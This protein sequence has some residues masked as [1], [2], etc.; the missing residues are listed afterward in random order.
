MQEDH[1]AHLGDRGTFH[2]SKLRHVPSATAAELRCRSNERRDDR[3]SNSVFQALVTTEL[4]GGDRQ[5]AMK[6][7]RVPP[8]GAAQVTHTDVDCWCSDHCSC[9]PLIFMAHFKFVQ[10]TN[11]CRKVRKT[12]VQ[13][14]DRAANISLYCLSK[15]SLWKCHSNY[16]GMLLFVHSYLF[17]LDQVASLLPHQPRSP[18]HILYRSIEFPLWNNDD[19]LQLSAVRGVVFVIGAAFFIMYLY[20]DDFC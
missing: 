8:L 15:F 13:H 19:Y 16:P 2:T 10:T 5:K 14:A 4:E 3:P 12:V 20:G 11:L 18:S 17:I 9:V 1:P 6:R 7:L